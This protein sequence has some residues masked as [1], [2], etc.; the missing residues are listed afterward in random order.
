MT[1]A[2][3]AQT[4]GRRRAI[5]N[6]CANRRHLNNRNEQQP[7]HFS[8]KTRG[9]KRATWA[10]FLCTNFY[11]NRSFKKWKLSSQASKAC[12]RG[13][14]IIMQTVVALIGL[15]VFQ[16]CFISHFSSKSA[17]NSNKLRIPYPVRSG[18]LLLLRPCATTRVL[19]RVSMEKKSLESDHGLRYLRWWGI[20]FQ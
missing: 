5:V 3:R 13:Y 1:H 11:A 20:A 7:A 15:F 18:S 6:Y 12:N 10:R 14:S 19:G 17:H 9:Q 8:M 4:N 2:C 16:S